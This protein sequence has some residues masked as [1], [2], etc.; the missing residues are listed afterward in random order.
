M[1]RKR[2]QGLPK[3]ISLVRIA[4]REHA[5]PTGRTLEKQEE[6]LGEEEVQRPPLNTLLETLEAF[7]QSW[8]T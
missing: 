7:G 6:P 1:G 3:Q 8:G 5:F 4:R 2:K